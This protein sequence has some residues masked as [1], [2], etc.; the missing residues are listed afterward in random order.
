MSAA[1]QWPRQMRAILVG[2][3]SGRARP[4]GAT[5]QDCGAFS[6][7]DFPQDPCRARYLRSDRRAGR[8]A[9]GRANA[10]LAA[11]LRHLRRAAAARDHQGAGAGQARIGRGQPRAG[12]AGREEDPGHRGRGRRSH[13]RQA[14]GRVP[15]GGLA[16]RLGHADQHERQ[17]GA[18]QPRERN[19]R[20]RAR[21]RAPRAPERRREPQ[22]VEQRRVPHRHARGRGRGHHAQAAARHRQAARHAGEKGQGLRRHRE[23]RPHPPAG[24]HAPHAGPGVLGLRRAARARR[25]ACARR[26][27]APVRTGAGRHGRRHRAQ[28]AEGLCGAGAPSWRSSRACRS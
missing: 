14:P 27:A 12:P 18:G 19:P 8:Q 7:D 25:S 22:P 28:C 21:G 20:R 4:G 26:A 13:R 17:R 3:Y 24:R 10:A 5:I 16:D 11:E 23:D 1:A 6:H 2:R 9:V 15:A